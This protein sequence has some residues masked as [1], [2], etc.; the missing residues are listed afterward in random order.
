MYTLSSTGSAFRKVV[1]SLMYVEVHRENI[2]MYVEI[3]VCRTYICL[4]CSRW[5]YVEAHREPAH[6]GG[7]QLAARRA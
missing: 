4:V 5:M 6:R 3:E 1:G 7:G 2:Q